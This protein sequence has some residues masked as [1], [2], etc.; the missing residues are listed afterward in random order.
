MSRWFMVVLLLAATAL[1]VGACKVADPEADATAVRG[2]VEED[3]TYFKAGTEGDSA[4]ETGLLDDTT[5]GL[6]WRGPQTHDP[7]P[8]IDVEV[9]GD[10]AWVG[11]HQSNYGELIHWAK[12]SDT[13]SERWT[14][15]LTER[16]QLNAVFMREGQD[17]DIDRGWRLKRISLVSGNSDTTSTVR[18]DSLRIQ[19]SIRDITIVDPLNTYYV[20]DSL[21]EFTPAEQLTFTMYTNATEGRAFLHAFWGWLLLRLPFQHQGDGVYS[22]VWNAQIIPGFRFAIFDLMTEST[23]L[24]PT[25]P[26]DYRGWLLPYR[27]KPAD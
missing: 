1:L 12:T 3:T 20:L 14:K 6:W 27:I 22:G 19:S 11:W 26:Y 13:T 24:D 23:L 9:A 15:A 16:V 4:E 7:Q 21:V 17:T 8:T 25:A 5:V 2:L 10:S 18:I